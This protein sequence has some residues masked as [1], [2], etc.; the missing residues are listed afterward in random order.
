MYNFKSSANKYVGSSGEPGSRLMK[1]ETYTSITSFSM[2]SKLFHDYLIDAIMYTE[3]LDYS[4]VLLLIKSAVYKLPV[5]L[6]KDARLFLEELLSKAKLDVDNLYKAI[7]EAA[8]MMLKRINP[9]DISLKV[10]YISDPEIEN[11]NKVFFIFKIKNHDFE[12]LQKLWDDVVL[13]FY[14][15]LTI[16]ETQIL[17]VSVEPSD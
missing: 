7:R 15:N 16:K 12:M 2:L 17:E 10:E 4:N 9:S 6:S 8:N 11:Y 1:E 13:A 14:S 5:E 3:R